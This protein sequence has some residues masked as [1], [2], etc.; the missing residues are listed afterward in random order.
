MNYTIFGSS[1]FENTIGWGLQ[2]F[3]RYNAEMPFCE[4]EACYKH[5][6]MMKEFDELVTYIDAAHIQP[7]DRKIKGR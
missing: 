3:T 5:L 4:F 1:P 7:T 2:G 6:Q